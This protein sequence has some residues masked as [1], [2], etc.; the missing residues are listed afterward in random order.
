MRREDAEICGYRVELV[1]KKIKNL[2]LYVLADGSVRISAPFSLQRKRIE[3][4]IVSKLDWIAK[5][6]S[7]NRESDENSAFFFGVRY[8]L[9][10]TEA[11]RTFLRFGGGNNAEVFGPDAQSRKAA[12]AAFYVKALKERIAERLP[13][14]ENVTGLKCSSWNVRNMRSRWGSCNVNTRKINFSGHL[15]EKPEICLDYLILHELAHIIYPNHGREFK[16]YL[17]RYMPDWKSVKKLLN[18]F[19]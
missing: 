12:V 11:D 14:W 7:S 19:E 6:V 16:E 15:A 18:T 5:R 10:E 13:A 2:H 4:F 1:R 9:T 3:E 8:R 17:S